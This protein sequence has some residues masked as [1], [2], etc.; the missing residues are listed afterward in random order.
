[1]S[2]DK[3]IKQWLLKQTHEKK[4][5]EETHN[6]E[7]NIYAK[8]RSSGQNDWVEYKG[9]RLNSSTVIIQSLLPLA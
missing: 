9:E 1:M 4:A 8:K 3:H 7:E 2:I 5:K 6:K